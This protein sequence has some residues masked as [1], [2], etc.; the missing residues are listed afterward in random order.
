M[1]ARGRSMTNSDLPEIGRALVVYGPGVPGDVDTFEYEFE[2]VAVHCAFGM[3]PTPRFDPQAEP[4]SVLLRKR[5]FSLNYRDRGIALQIAKHQSE[6]DFFPIGSDFVAEVLACGSDVAELSPG[7]RVIPDSAYP[8]S[9]ELGV[10]GGIPVNSASREFQVIPAVKLMRIPPA[11]SNAVAAGF[12]IGAQTAMAMERRVDAPAGDAVLVTS[13][14]SNTALFSIAALRRRNLQIH[15]ATRSDQCADRLRELGVDAVL[16][17]QVGADGL[18]HFA[19]NP[20]CQRVLSE[21]GGYAAVIDPFFDIYML[22]SLEVLKTSGAYVTC[23]RADQSS[24]LTGAQKR[25]EPP[26]SAVMSQALTRNLVIHGNCLGST[27]DL[28]RAVADHAAGL[29]RI[30]LDRVFDDPADAQE[31]VHRSWSAPDRLGKVVFLY[32]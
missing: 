6:G 23:G 21:R 9:R 5:G 2:S 14:R 29:F 22:A 7:D 31:F 18:P 26:I 12:T 15:A 25:S 20:E 11:M 28:A 10:R 27:Q 32:D 19:S 8:N 3:V 30:P 17:P 13:A 1:G 24:H 16:Q 4:R